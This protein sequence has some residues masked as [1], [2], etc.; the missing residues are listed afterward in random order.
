[1]SICAKRPE[2]IWGAVLLPIDRRGEIEW[3]ALHEQLSTLHESGLE[4]IY[5][6]GTAGEFH[7]QTEQE[8]DRL[9][10]LVAEFCRLVALPFQIGVS[11]SNARVAR[12]RLARIASLR[13]DAA[14]VTLPDWW[15]PSYE[16]AEAFLAGMAAT[17]PEVPLVLYNPPHAKRRLSHGEI[18]KLRTAIPTLIGAKLPGGDEFWYEELRRK[19][20][21]F[22]V[23]IPGHFM[24]S[25]CLAGG[26]GSYSNVACLSPA[27]A[28][29]WW[30]QLREDPAGALAFESRVI[31][32]MNEQVLPLA[33]RYGLSNAALDKALAAAGR[34]CSMGPHLLWPYSCA[35]EEAVAELGGAARRQLPELFS[36]N[37]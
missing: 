25:G 11:H 6:N 20:P 7:S 19:L 9:S 16:E 8:F 30:R 3:S 1:M 14:Q 27:G 21:D 13:P 23:F 10:Q 17:A 24:A 32:F 33:V 4:G 31:A 22:S 29:G 35:P 15:A 26:R 36:M 34:W 18:A 28:V 2:G 12:E 37:Q 5:T